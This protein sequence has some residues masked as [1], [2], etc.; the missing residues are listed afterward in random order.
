MLKQTN[1]SVYKSL[2]KRRGVSILDAAAQADL[3]RGARRVRCVDYVAKWEIN[4]AIGTAE[5][6]QTRANWRFILTGISCYSDYYPDIANAY[7]LFKFGFANLPISTSLKNDE[8]NLLNKVPSRCVVGLEGI[9]D[10]TPGTWF[11]F[12]ESK[13]VLFVL[14]ERAIIETEV[15]PYKDILGMYYVK[16][17]GAFLYTGVEISTEVS[18]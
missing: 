3:L 16:N 2:V 18:D 9:Q 10:V 6:V 11:H 17:R 5:T 1:E 12:E 8:P 13:N 4:G 7:P 14:P 15:A